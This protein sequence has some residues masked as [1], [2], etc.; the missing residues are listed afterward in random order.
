[1]DIVVKTDLAVEYLVD[2]TPIINSG[3]P[4]Y[5]H[6]TVTDKLVEKGLGSSF[7]AGHAAEQSDTKKRSQAHQ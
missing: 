6:G 3:A 5:V 2:V 4:S 1:M 7:V